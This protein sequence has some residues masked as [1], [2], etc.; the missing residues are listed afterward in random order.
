MSHPVDVLAPFPPH[1]SSKVDKRH[2]TEGRGSVMRAIGL[3]TT[4]AVV[5]VLG[6]GVALAATVNCAA[7]HSC[8]GMP[9]PDTI[10][11]STGNDE[12]YGY[13]RAD[14]MN[15]YGGSDSMQGD[16]G[17]DHIYGAQGPTAPSGAVPTS[18]TTPTR[19]TTTYMAVAG[20]TESTAASRR[21]EWTA[22]TVVEETT[23]ST[24]HSGRSQTPN[25]TRR[26]RR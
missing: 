18:Q 10:N 14:T 5:L 11:G 1:T 9:D 2:D 6:S 21:V 12:V 23:P 3:L 8:V 15:G 22:S 16:K 13:G 17:S 4:M 26:L 24:L 19:A 25:L 20:T 7:G